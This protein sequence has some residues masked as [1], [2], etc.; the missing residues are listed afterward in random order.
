MWG[1][2]HLRDSIQEPCVSFRPDS[3]LLSHVN[4]VVLM[5]EVNA[6]KWREEYFVHVEISHGHHSHS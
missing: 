1:G 3:R 2:S 6:S 5:F 4:G